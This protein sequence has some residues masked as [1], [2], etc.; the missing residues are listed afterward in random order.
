MHNDDRPIG[1]FLS[2][3]EALALFGASATASLAHRASAQSGESSRLL[4][5]PDCVAQ[6]EQTEGPYFVDKVLERSDIRLDPATG[7]ISAGAPLALQFVLSKVTSIGACAVLPGAQVDIWH[8]DALGVYSDVRDRSGDTVGQQFL[9]GYQV[10]D[11]EGRVRFNTIYPGWY[12]GRAVHIHFKIRVPG[13]G[14]RTDEFTS[15]LYFPDELTDRVHAAAAVR[16]EQRTASAQFPRHDLPGRRDA[17]DPAGASRRAAGMPRPIASPCV[18]A[19]RAGRRSAQGHAAGAAEARFRAE[20]ISCGGRRILVGRRA[21][22]SPRDP[23]RGRN[24][25]IRFDSHRRRA[26][27]GH[28]A[29][30]GDDRGA[31]EDL[32]R[33]EQPEGPGESTP[34]PRVIRT[35]TVCHAGPRPQSLVRSFVVGSGRRAG[36]AGG[37]VGVNRNPRGALFVSEG[38]MPR[39]PSLLRRF[40]RAPMFTA[41]VLV[42]LAIGIGANTAVFSVVNGVLIKPLPYPNAGRTG[43]RLALGAWCRP[44]Q[45]HRQYRADDVL[46][47]SRRG[48]RVSGPRR[49][50]ERWRYRDR[51]VGA[52]AGTQLVRHAGRARGAVVCRRSSGDGS[53]A[54]TIRRERRRRCC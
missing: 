7:R 29:A 5:T 42:T 48:T 49:V 6:P 47:L 26:R 28:H 50:V 32:V 43:R 34:S 9:R 17:A 23:W 22:S 51:S 25:A 35:A 44:Q 30:D 40:S 14:G 53:H 4:E 27:R 10:S 2:R 18:Q 46:H 20:T 54:R 38:D 52:R 36:S 39:L 31:S 45:R 19:R 15:Q 3:R 21:G 13:D 1:R 37:N 41:A 24:E 33:V 11:G 16:R 12:R 8:C